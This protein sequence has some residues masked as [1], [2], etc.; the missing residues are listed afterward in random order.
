MT[1]CLLLVKLESTLKLDWLVH[2][3]A[4]LRSNCVAGY[5]ITTVLDFY[6]SERT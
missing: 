3:A 1:A 5:T 2:Q 4:V 6:S